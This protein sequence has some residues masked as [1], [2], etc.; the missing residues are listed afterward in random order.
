MITAHMLHFT[1]I[2]SSMLT[3]DIH[4]PSDLHRRCEVPHLDA[5]VAVSAEEVPAGSRADA[6]G[7]LTLMHHKRR[8]GRPVH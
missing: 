2:N 5:A 4:F 6:A 7:S 3:F 1:F 8:N